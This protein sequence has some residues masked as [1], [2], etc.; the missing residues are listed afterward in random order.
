M[1]EVHARYAGKEMS[2]KAFL[3]AAGKAAGQ[4][5]RPVVL[6]WLERS[7]LPDI[8]VSASLSGGPVA[9]RGASPNDKLDSTWTVQLSM[10]QS[11]YAYRLTTSVLVETETRKVWK[12]I[13]VQ[14]VDTTLA[15]TMQERPVH[16]SFNA[17]N[18]IS[19]RRENFYT[20]ANYFDDYDSTLVVYG[21]SQQ[22]DANHTLALRYQ[23]VLAD[24]FTENLPMLR[25]DSEVSPADLASHDLIVLGGAAENPLTQRLSLD[26]GIEI[27]RNTFTWQEKA[28]ASADEGAI[29]VFP[30]PYN[31]RKVA[32]LVAANSALQLYNMT[33][34][35]QPVHSWGIFKGS[36]LV[37]KGYHGMKHFD[38]S[39]EQLSASESAVPSGY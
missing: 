19:V 23:T 36:K 29:L 9:D 20:H 17:G 28:Y 30:N 31:P 2:T 18:D 10:S 15:I 4:D 21:T 7:D 25:K 24:A 14:G 8:R 3:D 16:V 12:P 32:Y 11:G 22:D 33:K 34:R 5:L 37:E 38:I 39:L 35:H 13:T 26:L 6:P 1:N 27:G